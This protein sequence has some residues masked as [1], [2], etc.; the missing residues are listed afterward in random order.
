[1]HLLLGLTLPNV[2]IDVALGFS[3]FFAGFV[4]AYSYFRF[5]NPV[6]EADDNPSKAEPAFDIAANDAARTNMAAQQLR[7]LAQN[8]A[9]DVGAH[10]SLVVDISDQLGAL[11]E[12]DD[13]SGAD[14]PVATIGRHSVPSCQWLQFRPAFLDA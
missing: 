6:K 5:A 7:D 4:A 11:R 12:D 3:A 1:M 14:L 13:N 2:L 10:N 9:S 8:V